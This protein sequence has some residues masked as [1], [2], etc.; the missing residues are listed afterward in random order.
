MTIFWFFVII[1]AL[2]VV[3]E[4]GH[5]TV[6]K[7]SGI[8]VDEFGIGFPPRIC[9]IRYG[10]TIYSINLIPFGGF[11]RIFGEDPSEII[12]ED[13]ERSFSHKPKHIQAAV[14]IAG[15][16]CNLIF[17]WLIFCS[18]F[19][20]GAPLSASEVKTD[21]V[22]DPQLTIV[23]MVEDGAALKAG[24]K[25]GDVI[26]RL[27]TGDTE[28]ETLD[29]V[30]A[31]TFIQNREGDIV[32]DYVRG[33]EQ[34]SVIFTQDNELGIYLDTIGTVRLNPFSAI[35]AGTKMTIWMTGI[36]VVGLA[37]FFTSLVMGTADLSTVAGPV[38]IVGMVGDASALGL[39]YVLNFIAIISI[40]LTIINLIPF[41]ALDGGRLF[42]LLVEKIKGSPI[43]PHIVNIVNTIGFILLILLMIAITYN[44]IAN[45][46]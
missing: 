28:L 43:R 25:P 35:L 7:L 10:E 32:I 8:R 1:V 40:H 29:V 18:M 11:V 20:I 24:L 14:L 22:R 15:V 6:A 42:F 36:I 38:G 45:L 21:I 23:E 31:T 44:D 34:E 17:A 33:D 2:I 30:Q 16:T 27:T 37:Q 5:F 13:K 46:F 26:V 12:E 9:S 19:M 4:L 39:V 3:H 41:P